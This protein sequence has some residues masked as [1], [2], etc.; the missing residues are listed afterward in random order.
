MLG[1]VAIVPNA[2]FDGGRNIRTRMNLDFLGTDNTP[3]ALG[4]DS[5]IRGLGTR[6]SMA[7][8]ITMRHL[9]KSIRRGHRTDFY[10]LEQDI[11]F[12]ISTHYFTTRSRFKSYTPVS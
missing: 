5:S 3:S 2:A 12:W 10:R 6:A 9:E 8:R 11:V 7:Q 4:L 1:N